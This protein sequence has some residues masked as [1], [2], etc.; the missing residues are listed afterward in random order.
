M[1]YN[2]SLST[3]EQD[4]NI[5]P[6]HRMKKNRLYQSFSLLLERFVNHERITQP[7]E[8]YRARILVGCLVVMTTYAFIICLIL[9]GE[10]LQGETTV[11][12]GFW[13]SSIVGTFYLACLFLFKK[14]GKILL[15]AHAFALPLYVALVIA[16][17]ISGGPGATSSQIMLIIPL[18]LFFTAG[19]LSGYIW[20]AIVLATQV[21][22]FILYKHGYAFTLSMNPETIIEQGFLHWIATLAGIVGIARVYEKAH[23]DLASQRDLRESDNR[24]LSEHDLLTGVHNR[25]SLEKHLTQYLKSTHRLK[26]TLTVFI[27]DIE[28]FHQ[29]NHR[30]GYTVGDNILLSLASRL[31]NLEDIKLAGRTDGNQFTLIT[32]AHPRDFDIENLIQKVLTAST[33]PFSI[34]HQIVSITVSIGIA[35]FHNGMMTTDEILIEAEDSLRKTRDA[36]IAYLPPHT[37]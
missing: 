20:G 15:I 33:Q 6:G 25:Q 2:L 30:Y 10:A 17:F 23:L 32:H 4:K 1:H 21:I 14:T 8:Q 3:P 19:I 31:K 36:G 7:E 37:E 16:S 11:M 29:L 13:M 26:M 24:Y 5:T 28:D 9:L 18:I 34:G 35:G 27:V 12:I 22:I